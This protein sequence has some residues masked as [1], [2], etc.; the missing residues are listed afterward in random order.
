[1]Q[2]VRAVCLHL[3]DE[4]VKALYSPP[5]RKLQ[6]TGGGAIKENKGRESFQA[7]ACPGQSWI[8]GIRT[9]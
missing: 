6:F 8:P 5:P 7:F 4:K 3:R 2:E 9:F 1:M